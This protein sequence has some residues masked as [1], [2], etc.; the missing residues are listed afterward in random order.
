VNALEAVVL[1]RPIRC[2]W[3]RLDDGAQVLLTGG[4]RSHI[5]AVSVA[6]P[7][8]AAQTTTFPGHKDHLLSAPWSETL[9]QYWHCRVCVTCGIHYDDLSREG[10]EEVMAAV[11]GMLEEIRENME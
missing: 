7:G 3:V 9:A 8:S 1:G 10:L 4:D 2:Q 11:A 6:E 5:G